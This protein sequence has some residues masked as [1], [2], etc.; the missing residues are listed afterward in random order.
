MALLIAR[1]L[2]AATTKA[3]PVNVTN[4]ADGTFAVANVNNGRRNGSGTEG[5][6][7]LR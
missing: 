3:S 5:L 7:L 4:N 2:A 1:L 6:G